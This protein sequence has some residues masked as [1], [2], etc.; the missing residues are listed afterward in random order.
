MGLPR[1]TGT[2]NSE[3]IN[4]T[5]ASE[6]IL[7]LRG[8]D[9]IS[10]GLGDDRI[11]GG[12]GNDIIDGGGGND[13]LRGDGG[14]DLLTGGAGRDRFI[15]NLQGGTDTVTD[16]TN[17]EDRMDMTNFGLTGFDALAGH[18]AQVAADTVITMDGG[19]TIVLQNVLTSTIDAGD[20]RF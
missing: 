7:G 5:A 17:G 20:F 10:G 6:E 8:N 19:E 15:F 12:K 9:T 13:R 1:I 18:I 14:D 11:R 2:N 4:G 16:F 3:I